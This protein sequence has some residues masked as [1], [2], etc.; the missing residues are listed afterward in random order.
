MT[1][2]I[3]QLPDASEIEL[4]H[5]SH[6]ALKCPPEVVVPGQFVTAASALVLTSSSLSTAFRAWSGTRGEGRELR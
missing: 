2:Q 5:P 6:G 1:V 3:A 4:L